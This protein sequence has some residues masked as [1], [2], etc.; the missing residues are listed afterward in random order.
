MRRRQAAKS[1]EEVIQLFIQSF[2]F[3]FDRGSAFSSS[4]FEPTRQAENSE[5][6]LELAAGESVI[7]EAII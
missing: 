3:L 2:I 7:D 5:G 6:G 1:V 4:H